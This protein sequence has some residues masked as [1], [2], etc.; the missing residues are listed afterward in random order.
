MHRVL[1]WII[2]NKEWLFSGVGILVLTTAFRMMSKKGKSKKEV[3]AKT[4]GIAIGDNA[5]IQ[6]S[7]NSTTKGD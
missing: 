2:E 1:D 6:G 5:N 4:G 3:K 7:F